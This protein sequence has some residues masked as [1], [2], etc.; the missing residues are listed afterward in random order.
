M[1][2]DID[3][4]NEAIATAT[5]QW[6]SVNVDEADSSDGVDNL[7]SAVGAVAT[8][9]GANAKAI[10]QAPA[11]TAEATDALDILLSAL[12]SSRYCHGRTFNDT[13]EFETYHQTN[14]KNETGIDDL[15]F[16]IIHI[17]LNIDLINHHIK[18]IDIHNEHTINKQ[19]HQQH[20]LLPQ[21][22]NDFRTA[23]RLRPTRKQRLLI[24][25]AV[26]FFLRRRQQGKPL[27]GP[28]ASQRSKTSGRA[29]PEVAWLYDPAP[30]PPNEPSSPSR[31]HQR[32]ESASSLL[33]Q[34]RQPQM[35]AMAARPLGS[36]PYL[37]SPELGPAGQESP[38]LP[39]NMPAARD[40]SPS[41]S[42]TRS[43]S[44]SP[45]RSA[46]SSVNSSAGDRRP[47]HAIFEET[48]AQ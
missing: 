44:Q 26:V 11:T 10:T 46:R 5:I 17:D 24:I 9:S 25:L 8:L 47:L 14:D 6:N 39:P 18:L 32:D 48:H 23:N 45:R 16:N 29:Y 28:R 22:N 43:G 35:A 12:P 33:P 21:L 19:Q 41:H 36:N 27:F 15:K 38:L 13:A 37:R 3:D 42:P 2:S 7:V 30:T 31:G 4:T 40:E 34:V 20:I 1:D